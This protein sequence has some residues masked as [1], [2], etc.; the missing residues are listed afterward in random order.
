MTQDISSRSSSVLTVVT[1]DHISQ[2]VATLRSA[3]RHAA[4]SSFHLFAIDAATEAIADLRRIL[5]EDSSWIHIFG[6]YDLGPERAGFL[7]VFDQYNAV[8]LSCLA[9][10]V[11]ISHLLRDPSAGK[12][13]IFTDADTLFL[14]DVQEA[15]DAM[16]EDAVL[17]TPHLMAPSND[18]AEHD[19]MTHGWMNAGFLAFRREHPATR[20]VLDWLIDRIS[21]R[22]YFAPQY[23]L[24]CDQKWVSALPVL[25]RDVTCVSRH[26][27][28]NVGY[29]NLRERPLTRSGKGI[30]AGDSPLL[31]FHFSGF[32]WS[33]SK[34]LSKHSD[35]PV[36]PGSLLEELCQ[37]YQSELVAAAGLRTGA[38]RLLTLPY[39]TA[40]LAER[41]HVGSIRHG[42]NII[43]PFGNIGVFSRLGGKIYSLLRKTIAGYGR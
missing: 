43:A 17:L 7:E 12:I 27:G 11:G 24:S 39:S 33:R 36:M 9:K 20:N 21:R 3:R 28:L 35:Y 23:G 34:R 25:F 8:E 16:G 19:I 4:D 32:D 2:A 40:C 42:T 1:V 22:G 5:N 6:P 14:D 10:Y 29:W 30:L 41:I 38:E 31:M 26:R 37:R 13:C 15:I 18:D